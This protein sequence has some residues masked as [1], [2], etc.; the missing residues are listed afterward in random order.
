MWHSYIT[1]YFLNLSPF[2]PVSPKNVE[3]D[4]ET[5]VVVV[6][7]NFFRDRLPLRLS[8]WVFLPLTRGFGPVTRNVE[9]LNRGAQKSFKAESDCNLSSLAFFAP[10]IAMLCGTN[11]IKNYYYLKTNAQNSYRFA[12]LSLYQ[13]YLLSTVV[14]SDASTSSLLS[15][16]VWESILSLR[17][18]TFSEKI[19]VL[20][21]KVYFLLQKYSFVH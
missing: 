9:P 1:E 8:S 17:K 20:W 15:W 14:C 16:A 4:V 11:S 3:S 12:K 21:K 18:Y 19:H 7:V 2:N 10:N 6:S 5:K 13:T